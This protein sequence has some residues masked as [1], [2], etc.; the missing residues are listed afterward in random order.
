MCHL[1]LLLMKLPSIFKLSS[2][3]DD[4]DDDDD[5]DD[6]DTKL[7]NKR[8]QIVPMQSDH[9]KHQTTLLS[10]K[11]IYQ[12]TNTQPPHHQCRA[13]G[14]F[15]FFAMSST[16]FSTPINLVK[17]YKMHTFITPKFGK[18]VQNAHLHHT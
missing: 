11:Q 1:L 14:C 8:L 2:Y 12:V 17:L 15:F 16:I 18:I 5:N 13:G 6:N 4:V 10:N 3:N 7:H 9:V